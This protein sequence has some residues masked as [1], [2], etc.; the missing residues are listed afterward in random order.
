MKG[1]THKCFYEWEKVRGTFSVAGH[2]RVAGVPPERESNLDDAGQTDR[3]GSE[4]FEANLD[5]NLCLR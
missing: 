3:V 2:S 5:P 4:R 1:Q